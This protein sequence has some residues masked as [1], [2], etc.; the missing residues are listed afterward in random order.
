[1]SHEHIPAGPVTLEGVGRQPGG[2]GRRRY[3]K[4]LEELADSPGFREFLHREFPE[5]ASSFDDPRGRRE[6]LRLMGASLALAGLTACTQQPTEK[7]V[8]YVRQPEE[9]VPGRPLFFATAVALDGYARGRPGREPRGTADEDRGQ[10]RAPPEPRRDRRLRPGRRPR[11]LRPRPLEDGAPPGPGSDLGRVP[12]GPARGPGGAEAP[13]GGRLRFLTETVTSPTLAA[14][15]DALGAELPE[16]RWLP[17]SPPTA[18]T[19]RGRAPR[20]RRAGRGPVPLRERRRDPQPRGRFRREPPGEP[21]LVREFAARRKVDGGHAGDEPAV[22]G[23]GLAHAH[24]GLRRP[25]PRPPQL[26]HRGLRPRGGRRRRR[27]RPRAAVD[28]EWVGPLVE[29]LKTAAPRRGRPRRRDPARRRCTPSPTRSTR[30]WAR[31]ADHGRLHRAGGGDRRAMS[32]GLRRPGRR[33]EGRR[34]RGPGGA[35]RQPGLRRPGRP[36]LRRGRSRR[37]RSASTS[38]S[39][40]TRRRT[41]ATGTSRRRTPSSPGATRAPSTAPSP[42]VQ[43]LIAPLYGGSS[44]HELVAGFIGGRRDPGLRHPA[45]ALG[46]GPRRRR[47]FEAGGPRAPRRRRGRAPRSAE[48]AVRGRRRAR[49]TRPAPAEPL[50]GLELVFRPDP[51]STTDASPTTAGC[52]SCPSPLTKLTWDNAALMSPRD[53]REARRLPGGRDR[54]RPRH[55]G[56]RAALPA[57]ARCGPRSGSCPARPTTR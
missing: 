41:S 25:P 54:R 9:L 36:R 12:R 32:T 47:R 11:P 34:G 19:S 35:G 57:D 22:R 21:P 28:R 13:G 52:R 51:R 6:F 33:D 27:R 42:L 18:T 17:G 43:P 8:P 15:R 49:W 37:C 26:R 40:S 29:D 3:W 24:R 38:G 45:G 1:M 5:Q 31:S 10:P 14:Q 39:T 50:A 7:I 20:L 16:A 48:K 44:A 30:P 2:P 56:G 4:S 53:G 46:R 23:R 55:R